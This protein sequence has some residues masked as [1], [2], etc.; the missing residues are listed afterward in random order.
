MISKDYLKLSEIASYSKLARAS[1]APPPPPRGGIGLK[2]VPQKIG[3][4]YTTETSEILYCLANDDHE[5]IYKELYKVFPN[6]TL[7]GIRGREGINRTPPSSI[8]LGLNFCSLTDYQK[9]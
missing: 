2:E 9:L 1:K 7:E 8:F 3:V 4:N 5:E 6:L